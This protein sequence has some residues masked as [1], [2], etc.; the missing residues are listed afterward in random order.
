MTAYEARYRS[1]LQWERVFL[2][3]A[4]MVFSLFAFD[5]KVMLLVFMSMWLN[6]VNA[7]LEALR[8]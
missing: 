4:L 2:E 5:W 6:N 7:E 3:G 1:A 8:R